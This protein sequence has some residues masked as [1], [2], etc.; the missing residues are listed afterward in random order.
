MRMLQNVTTTADCCRT[1]RPD[2][3]LGR[4]ELRR[5]CIVYSKAWHHTASNG[6]TNVAVAVILVDCYTCTH[7]SE[8][9]VS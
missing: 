9:M 5:L 8:L 1:C 3:R 7:F 2:K 4:T 6:G